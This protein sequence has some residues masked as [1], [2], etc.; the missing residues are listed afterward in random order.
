MSLSKS[1]DLKPNYQRL[2]LECLHPCNPDELLAS[3]RVSIKHRYAFAVLSA[4]AR[5]RGLIALLFYTEEFSHR[6]LEETF[7]R[8]PYFPFSFLVLDLV[9]AI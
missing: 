9:R 5:N 6:S 8:H 1:K 7:D 4:L 3:R 2:E